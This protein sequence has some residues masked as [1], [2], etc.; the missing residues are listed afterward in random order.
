M[1]YLN[2]FFF[3][4]LF[5]VIGSVYARF[6]NKPMCG[7]KSLHGVFTMEYSDNC[8]NCQVLITIPECLEIMLLSTDLV[9]QKFVSR[10]KYVILDEVHCLK[11]N[12]F[13]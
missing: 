10:I 3:D 8:L 11:Y 9:V 13:L 12:Y 2:K 4:I 7:G 1:F 5:K 6:R